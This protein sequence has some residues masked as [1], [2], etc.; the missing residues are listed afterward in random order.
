MKLIPCVLVVLA[1]FAGCIAR[2]ASDAQ[3]L[4]SKIA[5]E[6]AS[7]TRCGPGTVLFCDVDLGKDQRCD[8]VD[9]GDLS[10]IR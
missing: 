9:R 3:V 10:R 2:P 7:N 1:L 4:V 6:R 5:R 8:C